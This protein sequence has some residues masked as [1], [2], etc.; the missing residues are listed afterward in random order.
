MANK[1]EKPKVQ[2]AEQKVE[3]QKPA[4]PRF[5]DIADSI[6]KLVVNDTADDAITGILYYL[7]RVTEAGV[8]SGL[9]AR[10]MNE[11]VVNNIVMNLLI[12]QARTRLAAAPI[13]LEAQPQKQ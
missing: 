5:I 7:N 10:P 1:P 12:S 13:S 4:V 6:Q 8:Q 9:V 11:D 2:K 3:E